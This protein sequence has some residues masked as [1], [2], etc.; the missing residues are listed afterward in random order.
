MNESIY[1]GEE[2]VIYEIFELFEPYIGNALQITEKRFTVNFVH[3]FSK[4]FFLI[5]SV[6][7]NVNG[8]I[9]T[10]YTRVI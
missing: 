6:L 7:V 4:R 9:S 10:G 8:Y 2:Q 5:F 3:K 1:I